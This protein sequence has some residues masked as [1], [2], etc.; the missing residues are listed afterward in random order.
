MKKR[1][2]VLIFTLWVLVILVILSVA[3]SRRASTDIK[4]AKYESDNIKAAYLARAG[5]MKMLL[6]LTRDTNPYDSMN[7]NWNRAKADPKTLQLKDDVIL[8]GASDEMA[9]LNLNSGSLNP[10]Y[11]V[12]LGI[13]GFLAEKLRAYKDKKGDKGFEFMEELFLVEEMT[14]EIYTEIKD[15][16]TI[17]RG[18]DPKVNINTAGENVLKA[19]VGDD[20]LVQDILDYRKGLDGEESTDDDG[21]KDMAELSAIEKLDPGLFTV[22]SSVFRIWAQVH[23][24]GGEEITK[25]IEAVIDRKTGK[26][27]YWREY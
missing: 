13:D 18:N 3:L 5:I 20:A 2:S 26:I 9:R 24:R 25:E 8:Y 27:Y 11:L 15:S 12:R 16:V 21:F 14:R 22:G 4:L 17:Y 19:V 7:E 1:G 23:L 6:E 10:A